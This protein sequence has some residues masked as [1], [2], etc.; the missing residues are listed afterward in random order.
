[1]KTISISFFA[2]ILSF[3]ILPAQNLDLIYSDNLVKLYNIEN[4]TYKNSKLIADKMNF[5][6]LTKDISINMF[7]KNQ[8]IKL[9][10]K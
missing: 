10:Y 1:M 2:F 3:W 4:A 5:D 8:K 7:R 6:I 9:I